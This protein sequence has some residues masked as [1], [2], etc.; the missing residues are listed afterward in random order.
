MRKT[1]HL[2]L[3]REKPSCFPHFLKKLKTE[4]IFYFSF[5]LLQYLPY[6]R[7]TQE[8]TRLIQDTQE[9]YKSYTRVKREKS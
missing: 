6:T 7:L 1:R 2:N 9:F 8:Y 4:D 5:I 3:L